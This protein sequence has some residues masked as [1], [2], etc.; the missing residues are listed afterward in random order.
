M[1]PARTSCTAR[2]GNAVADWS[3]EPVDPFFNVNTPE[4]AA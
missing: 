2:H 3:A 4:N 1:V